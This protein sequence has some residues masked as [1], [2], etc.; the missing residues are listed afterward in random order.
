MRACPTVA[1]LAQP[2]NV[3]CV[4]TR[5]P[6]VLPL[7]LRSLLAA[8]RTPC[9]NAPLQTLQSADPRRS[10]LPAALP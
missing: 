2:T 6:S 10:L 1:Q 5:I 8:T 7:S 3:C 9:D 4:H